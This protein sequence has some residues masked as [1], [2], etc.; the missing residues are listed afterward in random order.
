MFGEAQYFKKII[1][2]QNIRGFF[3]GFFLLLLPL[4]LRVWFRFAFKEESLLVEAFLP[5]R[6]CPNRRRILISFYIFFFGMRLFGR[7]RVDKRTKEKNDELKIVFLVFLFVENFETN[8]YPDRDGYSPVLLWKERTGKTWKTKLER[9]IAWNSVENVLVSVFFEFKSR[10]VLLKTHRFP[11]FFRRCTFPWVSS[12]TRGK[13]FGNPHIPIPMFRN[14][15]KNVEKRSKLRIQSIKTLQKNVEKRPKATR[16]LAFPRIK[17]VIWQKVESENNATLVQLH[18]TIHCFHFVQKQFYRVF[19]LQKGLYTRKTLYFSS[20]FPRLLVHF[21]NAIETYC[22]W[23]GNDWQA[24]AIIPSSSSN[25]P[26]A[27]FFSCIPLSPGLF[28]K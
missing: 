19:T 26:A 27:S 4:W 11:R 22:F 18:K 10:Q 5:F 17:L 16:E 15:I 23:V 21:F 14:S 24:S 28:N 2:E 1:R 13:G 3:P 7:R 9:K 25:L 6:S 8:W 12:K 20:F